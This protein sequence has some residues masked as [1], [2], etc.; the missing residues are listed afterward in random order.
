[1]KLI[2]LIMYIFF[3]ISIYSSASGVLRI[4]A[5]VVD[6]KKINLVKVDKNGKDFYFSLNKRK[7][8]KITKNKLYSC[9]DFNL[10]LTDNVCKIWY[11]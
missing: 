8:F 2:V 3:S 4:T 5:R 6:A 7:N 1:M 9:E 11:K 10:L